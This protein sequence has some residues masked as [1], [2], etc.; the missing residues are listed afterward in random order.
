MWENHPCCVLVAESTFFTENPHTIEKI[1][2]IH[3]RACVYINNNPEE[4]INVGVKYTG[5]DRES[6][7]KA[8]S[9]IVFQTTLDKHKAFEYVD[10]LRELTYI[11]TNGSR[12][13]LKN[14]LTNNDL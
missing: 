2:N 10:F 12:E 8:L 13:L 9:R 5:M 3:E 1:K 7:A 14:V 11:K 4:S 6:V